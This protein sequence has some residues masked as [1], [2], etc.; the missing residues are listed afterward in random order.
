MWEWME[1]N[2]I[3]WPEDADGDV[4]RRMKSH[5]FDFDKDAEID[6][7]VDFDS[8][9]PP[10]KILESLRVNYPQMKMIEPS[11]DSNGY[12]LIVVNAKVTYDLVMFIQKSI[13]DMAAPYGGICESWGVLH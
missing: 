12:I 10:Q 3:S 7:N 8:W 2:S 11:M 5:G 1:K 4:L 6:F 9:P 13:S